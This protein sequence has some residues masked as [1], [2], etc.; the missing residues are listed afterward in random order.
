MGNSELFPSSSCGRYY[1]PDRHNRSQSSLTSNRGQTKTAS[2]APIERPPSPGVFAPPPRFRTR[3]HSQPP[4]TNRAPAHESRPLPRQPGLRASP[5]FRT[6]MHSQ[7]QSTNRAPAHE[8]RPLPRQPGLRASPRFRT[9][10]HSQPQSTNRAAPLCSKKK[11][12][13]RSKPGAGQKPTSGSCDWR[14]ARRR[15]T[16]LQL[17]ARGGT[18]GVA[19]MILGLAAVFGSVPPASPSSSSWVIF[20]SNFISA[21]RVS[22]ALSIASPRT[23]LNR[24]RPSPSRT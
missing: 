4:S 8:S 14:A 13:N 11:P 21:N 22:S 15:R 2:G 7:P 23:F 17:P 19:G 10:M 18:K 6:R 16:K 9:R 12:R 1:P 24:I 5:R 20:T 3:I